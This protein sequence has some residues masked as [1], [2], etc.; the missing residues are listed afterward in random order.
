[1]ENCNARSRP[2]SHEHAGPSSAGEWDD[3]GWFEADGWNHYSCSRAEGV[4]AT[5]L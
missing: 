1:L 5:P 2:R 4:K 3:W